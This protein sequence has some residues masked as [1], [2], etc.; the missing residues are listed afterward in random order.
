MLV[1]LVVAGILMSVALPAV[2]RLTRS[3]SVT[4]ASKEL[5]SAFVLA[6]SYAIKHRTSTYIVFPT[7]VTFFWNGGRA[8][9][10]DQEQA[11]PKMLSAYAVIAR[12]SHMENPGALEQF[13]YV[14]EWQQLPAGALL[15]PFNQ[16][17]FGWVRENDGG[18]VIQL[19]GDP[20]EWVREFPFPV[21][22]GEGEGETL[23]LS[24][25]HFNAQG[26]I[27]Y[28]GKILIAEGTYS[29]PMNEDGI[30]YADAYRDVEFELDQDGSMI[31]IRFFRQGKVRVSEPMLTDEGVRGS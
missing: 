18:N 13:S 5:A 2:T 23:P 16:K 8:L 3:N 19:D 27:E 31:M 6:R 22:Y 24:Y 11:I 15:V 20:P 9:T 4:I 29:Y 12:E 30:P 1:V 25:I 26:L 28:E 21:Q 17:L 7:P 10:A 14:R